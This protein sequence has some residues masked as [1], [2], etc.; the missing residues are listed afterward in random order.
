CGAIFQVQ[1]WISVGDREQPAGASTSVDPVPFLLILS[2]CTLRITNQG[3][4]LEN[5]SRPLL[6]AW[7]LHISAP[8]HARFIPHHSPCGHHYWCN[9]G[10]VQESPEFPRHLLQ[11]ALHQNPL[12]AF[13]APALPLT[14]ATLTVRMQQTR[15]IRQCFKPALDLERLLM[16]RHSGDEPS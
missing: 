10:Q 15:M 8:V 9:H 14:Q 3:L 2:P 7:H 1:N 16:V 11:L 6:L 5:I 12:Q 4:A 13:S